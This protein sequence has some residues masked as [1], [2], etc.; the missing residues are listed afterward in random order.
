MRTK[1]I[2]IIVWG[3]A[4]I[5]AFFM[6]SCEKTDLVKSISESDTELATSEAFADV[7]YEN[8][9]QITNEVLINLDANSYSN[10]GLKSTDDNVCRVVTVDHPDTTWFPKVI[11]IDYGDGCT[12][13]INHDTI[14]IKGII[15]ITIT[16]RYFVEGSQRIVE[17]IDYYVNDVKI[18]G[19][20]TIT[21]LGLN[22][23]G[24]LELQTELTNGKIIVN[25]TL[26]MTREALYT[27]ECIFGDSFDMA[28]DEFYITG[29][30]Q[31]INF[32]GEQ[33]ART[34][35]NPLHKTS[36]LFFV[37]G[38]IVSEVEGQSAVTLDYGDGE[39][40]NIAT[41]TKDGETIEIILGYHYRL[42]HRNRIIR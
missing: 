16:G 41:L 14:T 27:R 23:N 29:G 42:R 22:D 18:E 12:T 17:L 37:S 25:D 7:V 21:N 33:Y 11:T 28:D 10:T 6:T 19:T 9:D 3:V 20:R 5:F 13:I 39:C 36:C 38:T 26:F 34:I 2:E 1:K 32:F 8:V 40:D 15:Q 4:I 31:G 30:A 35:T 24:N